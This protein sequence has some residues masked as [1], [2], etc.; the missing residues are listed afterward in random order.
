[1]SVTHITNHNSIHNIKENYI[2]IYVYIY[3]VD[4]PIYIDIYITEQPQSMW[5]EKK[6]KRLLEITCKRYVKTYKDI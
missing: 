6:I 4:L 1:M 3:S 2:Y 5:E